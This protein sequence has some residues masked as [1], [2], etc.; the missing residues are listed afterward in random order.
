VLK[1]EVAP[2]D[3]YVLSGQEASVK[4]TLNEHTPSSLT[5]S[6]NCRVIY[7]PLREKTLP[8][9]HSSKS[10]NNT[11][12]YEMIKFKGE[13]SRTMKQKCSLISASISAV[14]GNIS[15]PANLC[16]LE[17]YSMADSLPHPGLLVHLLGELALMLLALSRVLDAAHTSVL[18]AQHLVKL[19]LPAAQQEVT[20]TRTLIN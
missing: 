19:L 11:V 9:L 12:Q 18:G 4:D 2:V 16:M 20:E 7:H 10:R 8:T 15:I 13:M 17:H 5:T 3:L 1:V 6:I 14:L